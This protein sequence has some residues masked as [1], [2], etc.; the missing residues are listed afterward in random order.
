M[1]PRNQRLRSSLRYFFTNSHNYVVSTRCTKEH[2]YIKWRLFTFLV[3]T[4]L[5][6]I[7]KNVLTVLTFRLFE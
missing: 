7:V 6:D 2:V 1:C 3:L 5:K 4:N